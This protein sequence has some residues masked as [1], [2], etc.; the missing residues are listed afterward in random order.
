M[1]TKMRNRWTINKDKLK[2]I[3]GRNKTIKDNQ[4]PIRP[5]DDYGEN[6]ELSSSSSSS[7]YVVVCQYSRTYF[8][9]GT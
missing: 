2:I 8:L 3:M 5:C 1:Q 6:Q 9:L 7:F 4:G